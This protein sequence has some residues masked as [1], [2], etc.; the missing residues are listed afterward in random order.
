M[1]LST[2]TV[3]RL[4]STIAGRRWCSGKMW[5]GSDIRD[6]AIEIPACFSSFPTVTMVAAEGAKVIGSL[7]IAGAA[8]Q[9]IHERLHLVLTDL[10]LRPPAP[11]KGATKE[12]PASRADRNKSVVPCRKSLCKRKE[13]SAMIIGAIPRP[14]TKP[15]KF[16]PLLLTGLYSARFSI[17]QRLE[18]FQSRLPIFPSAVAKFHSIF[19][20]AV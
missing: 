4:N 18:S 13:Y 8:E 20:L 9:V 1:S 6:C 19:Q 3:A 2:R 7:T 11:R 12:F 16:A 5:S 15:L 17:A 10:E 14:P